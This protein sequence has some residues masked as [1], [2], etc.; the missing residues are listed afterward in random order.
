MVIDQGE[1]GAMVI[2]REGKPMLWVKVADP[3]CIL[4]RKRAHICAPSA[5]KFRGTWR[6][7]WLLGQFWV[8]VVMEGI[9]Q[10]KDIASCRWPLL[11]VPPGTDM[12]MNGFQPQSG[13]N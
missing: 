4:I 6:G 2:D 13:L 3:P 11:G 7:V 9:H 12:Q 10:A 1:R 5:E 8:R